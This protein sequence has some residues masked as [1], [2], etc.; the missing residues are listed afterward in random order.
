M[1]RRRFALTLLALALG[2]VAL[3]RPARAQEDPVWGLLREGKQVLLVRHAATDMSQRDEIGAPLDDCSRQRNLTEDGRADARKIRD[4]FRARGIPV[5]R[6]L[7]SPYCR[8]LETARLAFGDPEPWLPLQQAQ[9]HPEIQAARTAEI[10]RLAGTVPTGGNLVLVSHQFTIRVATGVSVEEGEMLV[11]SP[12]G[13][14]S[15]E[16]LGRMAPEDLPAQ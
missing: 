12:R 5:G 10:R 15:F 4:V 8:C 3:P 16:I 6:V 2:A 9:S 14:G 13:D 11:L 7:S 1:T